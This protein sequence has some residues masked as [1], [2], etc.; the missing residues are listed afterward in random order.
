MK[1]ILTLAIFIFSIIAHGQIPADFE[2]FNLTPG[3]FLDGSELS[4]GFSSGHIFLPNNYNQDYLS[5]TGFAISA[6]TDTLTPGFSNQYSAITGA[7]VDQ[8][9]AYAVRYDFAPS[10]IRFDEEHLGSVPLGMYITNSTYAYHS[11]RDGDAFAKKFGGESGDDPDW[12]RVTIKGYVD[13][14]LSADSIDFYLADYRFE[15][16]SQDYIIGEW[17]WVDLGN[18]GP[19]DSL[20]LDL[21]S[22]DV[23]TF[24]MNTPA[25]FCID[26]ITLDPSSSVRYLQIKSISVYPN[27][28]TTWIQIPE[29]SER[30]IIRI[31]NSLG[32]TVLNLTGPLSNSR[33]DVSHL[34]SGMYQVQMEYKGILKTGK[35]VKI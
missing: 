22:S 34:T 2:N 21:Q 33:V 24:G 14:Q 8:S 28:T 23:G 25:Y 29:F 26:N 30:G 31:V 4:G 10:V 18:L 1:P 17:T 20:S 6:T 3:E 19:C 35:F 16:N 13:G 7:G 12:F 9:M 11:V 15:D 5:W 27:P 32:A